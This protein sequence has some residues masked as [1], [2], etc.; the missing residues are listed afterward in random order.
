MNPSCLCLPLLLSSL[1]AQTAPNLIGVTLNTPLVVEINHNTC[2]VLSSCAALV[3]PPMVPPTPVYWPG[4]ATWDAQTNGVWATTGALLANI[5]PGTC[6]VNCGPVA[7][8]VTPGALCTGLDLHEG[9]DELW[10]IDDAGWIT[11]TTRSCAPVVT[12]SWFTGLVAAGNLATTGIT[13]DELRGL[14]FYSTA[15]FGVGTSTLYVAPIATPGLPFSITALQDCMLLPTL[16][17][18]LAVDAGN[19]VLYWTNGRGTHAWSYTYTPSGPSIAF[20]PGACC[21]QSAPFTDP[22]TDLAIRWGGATSTGGP[23]A[24]GNCTPCPMVHTLR[25]APLLGSTLQLG[26]DQAQPGTVTLCGVDIGPCNAFG[27]VIPPFCGPLMLPLTSALLVLGPGFPAGPGPCQASDTQLLALPGNPA[28][29][30]TVLSSQFVSL[31][32]PIGTAMSNCLTWAL[33]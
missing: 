2:S 17:T 11:T 12:N 30:G 10:F 14:V 26:L 22:L 8:P 21:L 25:T 23:C 29:V 7:C 5:T 32:S 3:L 1:V 18:G 16:C 24:N 13:V 20:T 28:L 9:T 33:Q 27:P 4:G 31:C 15:D 6:N 19:G